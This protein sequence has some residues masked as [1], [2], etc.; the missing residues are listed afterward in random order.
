[1]SYL[2]AALRYWYSQDVYGSEKRK[3][4]A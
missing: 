4:P 3:K 2:K 1:M